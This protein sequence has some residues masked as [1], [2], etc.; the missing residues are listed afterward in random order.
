[1]LYQLP[2]GRVVE[3]SLEDYLS[4]TDEEISSLV[5]YNIGMHIN[6]PMHGSVTKKKGKIKSEDD[7]VY[8]ERNLCDIPND[9][10]QKDQDYTPDEE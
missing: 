2:D 1:M 5:G 6:N 9:Y 10:K 7:E 3:I 8:E 4:C